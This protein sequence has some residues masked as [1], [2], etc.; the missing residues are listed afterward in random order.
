VRRLTWTVQERV[1]VL[2]DELANL[3]ARFTDQSH[4]EAAT[5]YA[6]AA[7]SAYHAFLQRIEAA[8]HRLGDRNSSPAAEIIDAVSGMLA[9]P[10]IQDLR[11][12]PV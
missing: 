1:K 4:A 7:G 9:D 3:P 12:P 8:V 11:Q 5:S 10:W 6:D 2:S